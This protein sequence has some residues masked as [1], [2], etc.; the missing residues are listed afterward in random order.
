MVSSR[1]LVYFNLTKIAAVPLSVVQSELKSFKY[2]WQQV[3][4]FLYIIDN[5]YKLTM[6]MRYITV[7][8]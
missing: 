8:K 1:L 4:L 2:D 6:K 7:R 5:N 3:N